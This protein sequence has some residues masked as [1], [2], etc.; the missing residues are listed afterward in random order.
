MNN[1]LPASA[2]I[3]S[4]INSLILFFNYLR[5]KPKLIVSPVHPEIY[6]CWV[7]LKDVQT[8]DE[9]FR[10]YAFFSYFNVTNRGL[11]DVAINGWRLH[12]Q[13]KL[14]LKQGWHKR[15]ELKP[16]NLPEFQ[17]NIGDHV[18]MIRIFGQITQN[19]H[20]SSNMVKSGDS[21]S[22]IACWIYSVHG[23][24]GWS[25]KTDKNN[26]IKATLR[27]RNAF[28]KKSQCKL[29]FQQFTIERLNKLFPAIDN[30]LENNGNPLL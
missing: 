11:R 15:Q 7:R 24:E 6:Q 13:N 5:D 27:I 23:G 2:L 3:L 16:Y 25:P 4:V 17:C 10:R 8:G 20:S 22:G 12:I 26:S 9:T 1:I 29:I 14:L 18:K 30:Y 19:F 28:G 21:I